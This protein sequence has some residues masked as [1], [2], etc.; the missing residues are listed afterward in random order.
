VRGPVGFVNGDGPHA[1]F[2]VEWLSKYRSGGHYYVSP[3]VVPPAV[4]GGVVAR[5]VSAGVRISWRSVA[6]ATSYAV[7]RATP[8]ASYT[9]VGATTQTSFMDRTASAGRTYR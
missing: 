6:D 4:P 1:F 7:W 2:S 5:S 9:R 8:G 3:E